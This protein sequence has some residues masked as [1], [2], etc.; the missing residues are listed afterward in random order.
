MYSYL[1]LS[2]NRSECA[3]HSCVCFRYWEW[4]TLPVYVRRVF[5]FAQT[6]LVQCPAHFTSLSENKCMACFSF[7]GYSSGQ[8]WRKHLSMSMTCRCSFVNVR[9]LSLCP[10]LCVNV[11]YY[12]HQFYTDPPPNLFACLLSICLS[13]SLSLYV[14]TNKWHRPIDEILSLLV[15]SNGTYLLTRNLH[16]AKRHW[17]DD[18][19][20]SQ[21]CVTIMIKSALYDMGSCVCWRRCARAECRVPRGPSWLDALRCRPSEA[22][23]V[24]FSELQISRAVWK[25]RW[26]SGAPVHNKPSV[27]V[28]VKQYFIITK[29]GFSELRS[30]VKVEVA[31]LGSRP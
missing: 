3:S 19:E 11:M 25:S 30:C 1:Y 4:H 22:S 24:G 2:V 15:I 31:V 5:V 21:G 6:T 16:G 8:M 13:V 26:P 18:N 10:S 9:K 7:F 12:D 27:S 29:V 23:G 20:I 28:D 17:S 14:C